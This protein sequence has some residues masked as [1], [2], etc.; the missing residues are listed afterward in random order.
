MYPLFLIEASYSVTET[1][2]GWMDPLSNIL[3]NHDKEIGKVDD[4]MALV[5]VDKALNPGSIHGMI[6]L[7]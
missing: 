1:Q 6:W 4:D 5:A 7:Q 2:S 3:F